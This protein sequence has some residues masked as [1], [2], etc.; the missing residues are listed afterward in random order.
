[1][2]LN[3]L[4]FSVRDVIF[5]NGKTNSVVLNRAAEMYFLLKNLKDFSLFKSLQV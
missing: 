5:K 2:V 1:V 3:Q 4:D